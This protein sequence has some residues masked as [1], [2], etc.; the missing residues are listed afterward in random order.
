MINDCPPLH[1][2]SLVPRTPYA[3]ASSRGVAYP[4]PSGRRGSKER[5]LTPL[6]ARR[7]VP[8]QHW[9]LKRGRGRCPHFCATWTSR[10]ALVQ[11]GLLVWYA[12]AADTLA[13]WVVADGR[14]E[15]QR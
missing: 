15:H 14:D 11:V 2:L 9:V 8:Y 7:R 5:C 3:G 1:G 6:R 12:V 13:G 4:S 10:D